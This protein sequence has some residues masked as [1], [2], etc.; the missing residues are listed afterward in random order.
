[1]VELRLER[2]LNGWYLWYMQGVS[3][4]KEVFTSVETLSDRLDHIVRYQMEKPA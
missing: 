1:M 2:V 3:V 4:Q